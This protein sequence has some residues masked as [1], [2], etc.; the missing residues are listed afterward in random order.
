MKV[1]KKKHTT[2]STYSDM[3]ATLRTR[4]RHKALI[5]KSRERKRE[6]AQFAHDLLQKFNA[7]PYTKHYS[8]SR[9]FDT[10]LSEDELQTTIA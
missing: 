7:T 3:P 5:Q 9:M 10:G 1:K 6:K 8:V 4:R 2:N